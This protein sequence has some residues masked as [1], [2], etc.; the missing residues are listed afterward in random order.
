MSELR[1]HKNRIRDKYRALRKAMDPDTKKHFD[2]R[3]CDKFISLTSYR[4][5]DVLLMYA[6]LP[7]EIDVLPILADALSRGKTVAF[8]RCNDLEHTM[9]YHIVE[10]IS[11]LKKGAFGIMEP[12]PDLPVFIPSQHKEL[13]ML[14]F[15]PALCFDRQGYRLG[16]GKGYYDRYLT[17]FSGAKMG[18]CYQCCLVDSLPR[19]KYDTAVDFLLTE[20]GVIT[21]D[22]I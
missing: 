13:N 14:C 12:S 1:E 16:Y 11:Q 20:K 19:G 17:D 7:D 8:P 3:I 5:A 18:V 21:L 22:A 15:I 6:P 2:Q 4:F 9:T 10:D